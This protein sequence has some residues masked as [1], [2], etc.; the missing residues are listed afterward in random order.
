MTI[1]HDLTRAQAAYAGSMLPIWEECLNRLDPHTYE[2]EALEE[3]INRER[4]KLG[5]PVFVRRPPPLR[6][7]RRVLDNPALRAAVWEK[8]GGRCWYCNIQTIPWRT[9]Q[10]DHVTPRS[11]GGTDELENLVPA[12][13]ECNRKKG[14]YRGKDKPR[15][16][17][18]PT[19]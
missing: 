11:Q 6:P 15:T 3:R 8:T 2:A 19:P 5:L 13:D 9:F 1:P 14:P 10:I 16:Y 7:P 17:Q 12:C 18:V 4:Q